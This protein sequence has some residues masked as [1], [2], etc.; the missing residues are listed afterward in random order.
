MF[1]PLPVNQLN[2]HAAGHVQSPAKA[3]WCPITPVTDD[4]PQTIPPH[5][6]GAPSKV[7]D[8]HD[9]AGHLLMRVGRWD[10]A[11][12]EKTIR[13]MTYCEND[14]GHVRRY[15]QLPAPRLPY[16]LDRPLSG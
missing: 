2:G 8:Y 5:R 15:Q 9:A 1:L 3:Q 10:H 6:L 11:D 12:G 14:W 7:W 4:A 16:G 13:P